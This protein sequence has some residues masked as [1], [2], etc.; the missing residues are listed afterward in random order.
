MGRI[1]IITIGDELVEGRLVDTNA[2]AMSDRLAAEGFAVARHLSVGDDPAE[3][4]ATLREAAARS[5]AVLVSGGLGPTSDDLTAAAAADAFGRS[6]VR[7][8]EALEH[9][10]CFFARR[11]REMS[12]NNAKQ[13]DLPEGSE[14]LPNPRGT[15]TG[16]SLRTEGC[17]LYFMPGVPHELTAM[18]ERSVLPDLRSFLDRSTPRIATLKIF[19]TGESDVANLLEGLGDDLPASTRLTVQ[20]RATFP[21]IHVRL[22]LTGDDEGKVEATLAGLEEDA[23]RRLGAYVYASG[24]AAVDTTFAHCVIDDLRRSD[25]TLAVAEG[26]SG[27][28]V[29]ELL[30]SVAGS[31]EVFRGSIV[32]A[33]PTTT[34]DLLGIPESLINDHG[35]A[36]DAVADAMAR[37][38]RRRLDAKLGVAVVGTP[39]ATAAAPAGTIVVALAT[40]DG[41]TCR[42]FSFAV[43]PDRFR[44]IAAYVALGTVR[45]SLENRPPSG[46]A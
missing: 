14:L 36:G 19:G 17:R 5:D 38:V 33:S 43:D 34:V 6:L 7:F 18:F 11:G 24:G 22:V 20:Y 28:A 35:V 1:E 29:A 41:T 44:R 31:E 39:V 21:E 45:R 40:A 15:A 46:G 2:G 10:R 4:I 30:A 3:M 8:D 42:G 26:C 25:T 12:A 37:G 13:A 27:G 23:H 32:A 9:V 16:F